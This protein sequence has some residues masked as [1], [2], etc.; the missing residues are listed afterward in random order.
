MTIEPENESRMNL[1]K[2]V[3]GAE[4]MF[5]KGRRSREADLESAVHFFLARLRE[6]RLSSALRHGVRL[7]TFCR[8]SSLL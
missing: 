4:K 1:L 7:G 5:L 3:E 2:Q 8:G 6:L